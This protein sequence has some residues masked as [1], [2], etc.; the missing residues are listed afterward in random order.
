MFAKASKAISGA[1]SRQGDGI[2]EAEAVTTQ[3]ST[4]KTTRTATSAATTAAAAHRNRITGPQWLARTKHKDFME[5]NKGLYAA[6]PE[7]RA[8]AKKREAERKNNRTCTLSDVDSTYFSGTT[9]VFDTTAVDLEEFMIDL[10]GAVADRAVENL[11][12]TDNHSKE[13]RRA[14]SMAVQSAISGVSTAF[15]NNPPYITVRDTE[16]DKWICPVNIHETPFGDNDDP[17]QV[18]LSKITPEPEPEQGGGGRSYRRKT[19]KR[20][21]TNKRKTQKRSRTNKRRTNKKSRTNKRK[22]QKRSRTN[23]RRTQKI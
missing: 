19:H 23:K 17:C 15:V 10:E 9:I 7:R 16:K 14:R 21:R 3:T 18:R 6:S 8:K 22:T 13:E 1:L 12:T 11:D 20:S 5:K 2:H 4:A